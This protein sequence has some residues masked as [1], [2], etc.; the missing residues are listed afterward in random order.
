VIADGTRATQ[1]VV[2]G[3]LANI[4][5][6]AGSLPPDAP[7]LLIVGRAVAVGAEI[8]A[9]SERHSARGQSDSQAASAA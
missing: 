7:S 9:T 8:A 4:A 2:Y 3:S 1:Q 5:E 6:R